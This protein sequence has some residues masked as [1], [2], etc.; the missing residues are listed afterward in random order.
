MIQ[1]MAGNLRFLASIILTSLILSLRSNS[2]QLVVAHSH[3]TRS[4][5]S[6]KKSSPR[7][8]SFSDCIP[9]WNTVSKTSILLNQTEHMKTPG[10]FSC[11]SNSTTTDSE[12]STYIKN[13]MCIE[14][15]NDS[16]FIMLL[17]KEE[18]STFNFEDCLQDRR[19]TDET[20]SDGNTMRISVLFG[21]L[22]W[23]KLEP[24]NITNSFDSSLDASYLSS[25]VPSNVKLHQGYHDILFKDTNPFRVDNIPVVDLSMASAIEGRIESLLNEGNET[26]PQQVIFA[27][28]SQG[29]ALAQIMSAYFAHKNEH[30]NTTL[31]TFSSPPV[32]NDGFKEW[33]YDLPNLSSWRIVVSDDAVPRLYKPGD[34]AYEHAGHLIQYFIKK[35]NTT[36]G[37]RAYYRQEGNKKFD[38]VGKSWRKS[39]VPYRIL[40]MHNYTS[41]LNEDLS[42]KRTIESLWMSKFELKGK[43]PS[44]VLI[45]IF[46]LAFLTVIC[47]L[48]DI[49]NLLG[50]KLCYLCK[51]IF[52]RI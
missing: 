38:S 4:S 51:D 44:L 49:S 48:Y 28:Y 36:S 6:S 45:L 21:D 50:H 19:S 31:I 41:Y 16:S 14:L 33:N 12:S 24:R 1:M 34:D 35:D 9:S 10:V 3:G 47:L 37:I 23:T 43:I 29:G 7:A 42:K 27:G 46:N 20:E 15:D 26:K 30:L 13:D 39:S 18:I 22:N 2:S 25:E 32:G 40:S 5:S 11:K 17:L 8:T 52:V